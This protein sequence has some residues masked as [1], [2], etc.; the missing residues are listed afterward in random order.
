[1]TNS[2]IRKNRILSLAFALSLAKD[3][4]REKQIIW[5]L[6]KKAKSN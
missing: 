4:S 2:E 5:H 1:M 6:F 3:D